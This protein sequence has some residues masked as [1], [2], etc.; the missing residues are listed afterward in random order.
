MKVSRLVLALLATPLLLPTDGRAAAGDLDPLFGSNGQR[1]VNFDVGGS[2]ADHPAAL[3]VDPQGRLI[4]VGTASGGATGDR[5]AMTRLSADGDV[6]TSFGPG[7]SGKATLRIDES[8][9]TQ[10]RAAVAGPLGAC[11]VGHVD[12]ATPDTVR[13]AH[14]QCVDPSGIRIEQP[15]GTGTF[16]S[17]D[18]RAATTPVKDGGFERTPM[19]G[20]VGTGAQRDFYVM[21]LARS[22]APEPGDDLTQ[23]AT[24][25]TQGTTIL[26][27]DLNGQ[28]RADYATDIERIPGG[29]LFVTGVAQFAGEDNDF[30]I[31]KLLEGGLPD[32][33]FSGDAKLTL[34]FDLANSNKDDRAVAAAIDAQG[35]LVVVGTASR[36]AAG[37]DLDVALVRLLPNGSV[38]TSF[39]PNGKRVYSFDAL[40]PGRRDEV[41]GLA[42]DAESRI[43]VVGTVAVGM[44]GNLADIAVMRVAA[45]GELDAGF[46]T[47]G[48]R[49]YGFASNASGID[50][51][52]DIVLQEDAFVVL[53]EKQFSATDTDFVLMRAT[54]L[55]PQQGPLL[56]S[57]FEDP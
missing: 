9:S 10:G 55:A 26:A 37:S 40:M 24:F 22:S 51:G 20:S 53:G 17:I 15:F 43:Y 5:F 21:E 33:A 50:R 52:V 34:G 1:V 48:R 2:N 14:A 54:T 25:G 35:R 46:G 47:Q 23:Y 27:F 28:P 7:N 30:A 29:G 41:G 31:A 8:L 18:L 49:T 42:I 4:A 44:P 6:D 39:G 16:N 3:R 11:A 57:G 13:T 56:A 36:D 45:N 12:V 32:T 19:A 38:D